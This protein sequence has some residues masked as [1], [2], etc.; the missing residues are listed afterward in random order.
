MTTAHA[1]HGDPNTSHQ[2]AAKVKVEPC[3][4]AILRRAG[5]WDWWTAED[6]CLALPE[7]SDSNVRGRIADLCRHKVVYKANC[8]A[9]NKRGNL[10]TLYLL[11]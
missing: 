11:T 2:A 7:Y 6:M 4:E 1:R 8:Y 5:R 9:Q 10:V 3:R